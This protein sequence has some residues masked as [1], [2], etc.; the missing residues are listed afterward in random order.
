MP[1]THIAVINK[2]Q[3]YEELT[4]ISKKGRVVCEG[5]VRCMARQEYAIL[6]LKVVL[7]SLSGNEI[8]VQTSG[9]LKSICPMS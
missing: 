4:K 1:D 3:I 9:L 5:E 2:R 7:K 6:S 8:C